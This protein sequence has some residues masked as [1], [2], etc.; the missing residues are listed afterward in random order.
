MI[1]SACISLLINGYLIVRDVTHGM[2][3][4]AIS[5]GA[6]SLY[7][8]NPV[9]AMITAFIVGC[10]Q[11]VVQNL[12]ERYA[13]SRN[14]IISTVSWSLF[15]LSGLIGSFFAAGWKN[16]TISKYSAPFQAV[17]DNHG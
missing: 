1:G 2:V 9:Y 3:A 15:G 14:Y 11:S 8:I 5:V 16:Q 7:I 6:A 13:I 10:L 12:L 17:L 4:G